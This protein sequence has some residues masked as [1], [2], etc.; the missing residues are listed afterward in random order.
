MAGSSNYFVNFP[1]RDYRFGDNES[2][3]SFQDLSVYIDIFDQVRQYTSFYE[4]YQI[5]NNER[6]D[7]VSYNLYRTEEHYWTFFL[8]NEHLRLNGWPMDN[9]RI[10]RQ[11]K[12]YYPHI[13]CMTEGSVFRKSFQELRYDSM[14]VC[15]NFKEGSLLW[16]H[17]SRKAGR[18]I[19][20][21]HNLGQIW[22]DMLEEGKFPVEQAGT[23]L[24]SITE[25]QL[26]QINNFITLDD[27][28]LIS[29]EFSIEWQEAN[30]LYSEIL[31][32]ADFTKLAVPTQV[33]SVIETTRTNSALTHEWDA[34]QRFEDDSGNYVFPTYYNPDPSV[35][36]GNFALDWST[37]NTVQSVTYLERLQM[38]NDD[39]RSIQVIKPDAINKVVNEFKTLLKS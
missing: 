7:H 23:L 3:V 14:S 34:I 24:Y 20:L 22:V 31:L 29:P 10:Y 27:D 9:W 26:G 17:Q 25:D 21:N 5:Q 30:E 4:S 15:D 11:A 35:Y 37:V 28:P 8:L 13:V 36:S 33:Q 38:A 18:I 6:P 2:A 32:N 16:F 19:K 12:E 1:K 39:M